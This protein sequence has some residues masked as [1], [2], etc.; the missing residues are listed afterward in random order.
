MA[1]RRECR[2]KHNEMW[3]SETSKIGVGAGDIKSG[4]KMDDMVAK[5]HEGWLLN[6]W[7]PRAACEKSGDEEARKQASLPGSQ[8]NKAGTLSVIARFS[9][10][11]GC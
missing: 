6:K 3:N 11:R 5:V 1:I 10:N 9:S 4:K 2:D 8:G 7:A